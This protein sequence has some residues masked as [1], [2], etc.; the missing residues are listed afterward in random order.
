MNMKGSLPLLILVVLADGPCHGYRIA[1]LIKERSAGALD[2]AEGTLYPA[3]HT[4]E[5][6]GLIAG[7][8]VEENGRMRRY[9]RLTRSGTDGIAQGRQEWQSYVDSVNRVLGEAAS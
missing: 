3:L 8:E 9:Y 1:G 7:F 4:L 5:A 2:F 6:Q